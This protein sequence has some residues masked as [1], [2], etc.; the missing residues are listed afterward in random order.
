M[1]FAT[2]MPSPNFAQ[3]IVRE[4]VFGIY[5]SLKGNLLYQVVSLS[6]EVLEDANLLEGVGSLRVS[7]GCSIDN[8]SL[9]NDLETGG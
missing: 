6:A 9:A 7:N 8:K 4:H 2:D 1:P 3:G 5:R